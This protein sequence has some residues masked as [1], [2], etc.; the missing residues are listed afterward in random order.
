MIIFAI[1][2]GIGIGV[3]LAVFITIH[4]LTKSNEIGNSSSGFKELSFGLHMNYQE[5]NVRSE[6][7][8]IIINAK[9]GAYH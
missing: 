7:Y 4:K 3:S 5:N 1:I 2:F 6:Q 8:D 9:K